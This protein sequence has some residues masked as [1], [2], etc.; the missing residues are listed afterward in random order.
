MIKLLSK[1]KSITTVKKY[2]HLLGALSIFA[3]VVF[4]ALQQLSAPMNSEFDAYVRSNIARE[5]YYFGSFKPYP[6]AWLPFHFNILSVAFFVF[7]NQIA[8]R[9]LTLILSFC[10]VVAVYFL[11]RTMV[12]SSPLSNK[13]SA[14]FFLF[15]PLRWQLQTTALSEPLFVLFF[16]LPIILLGKRSLILVF[17]GC[18]SAS[19]AQGIRYEAWF[20]TPYYL[21]LLITNRYIDKKY[22]VFLSFCLILFPFFWLHLNQQMRG[23]SIYFFLEKYEN[24]QVIQ[25][26]EYFNLFLTFSSWIKVLLRALPLSGLLFF[27]LGAYKI[28]LLNLKQNY[29]FIFLPAYF[30]LLLVAQVFLGTMEYLM[31]RYLLPSLVLISPVFGQGMSFLIEIMKKNFGHG[32]SIFTNVVCFLFLIITFY[33][34]Y[35]SMTFEMF[36]YSDLE[37]KYLGEI[38]NYLNTI[39]READ[40]PIVYF[41]AHPNKDYYFEYVRYFLQVPYL[42]IVNTIS[43]KQMNEISN[44]LIVKKERENIILIVDTACGIE[45]TYLPKVFSNELADVYVSN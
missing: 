16:I 7:D 34:S 26:P 45:F 6:M 41:S 17:L 28:Y 19:L 20:L 37:R 3:V 35:I 23:D 5:N 33:N 36:R 9:F 42:N 24:A 10:S 2:T 14:L 44:P 31:P 43:C 13:L 1:T 27:L 11:S 12:D 40:K 21:Y 18:L 32:I 30:F 4:F 38:S 25:L 15:L 29:V 8:P 22:K 39:S